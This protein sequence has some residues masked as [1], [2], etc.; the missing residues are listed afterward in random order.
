MAVLDLVNEEGA[1]GKVRNDTNC[2]EGCA[3]LNWKKGKELH[4][5]QNWRD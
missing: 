3:V 4:N 1:W 5:S 2:F